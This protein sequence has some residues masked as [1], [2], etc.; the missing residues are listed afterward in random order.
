MREAIAAC[1]RIS[2]RELEWTLSDEARM[3]D[4]RWWISDLSQWQA[5]YPGWK[6][7]Y[8]L[9]TTLREIYEFN[10]ERWTAAAPA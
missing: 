3:G 8:D 6:L 1:E 10:V 5:D 4:H 7:E 2:G 9:E